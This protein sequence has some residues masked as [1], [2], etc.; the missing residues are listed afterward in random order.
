[1]SWIFSAVCFFI[2]LFL[3]WMDYKRKEKAAKRVLLRKAMLFFLFLGLLL[4][5][6]WGL[7][8]TIP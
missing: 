7:N 5:F 2:F 6:Y 3:L 4:A 1:M 8:R